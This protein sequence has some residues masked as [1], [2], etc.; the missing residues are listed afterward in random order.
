MIRASTYKRNA[1]TQQK[2]LHQHYK[3]EERKADKFFTQEYLEHRYVN[4]RVEMELEDFKKEIEHKFA[5]S[6]LRGYAFIRV[7]QE[8][9]GRE[10]DV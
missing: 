1:Q 4:D 6:G 10:E 7:R 3:S 8:K 9:K 2:K 5:K